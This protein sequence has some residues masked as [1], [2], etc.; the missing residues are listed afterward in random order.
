VFLSFSNSHLSINTNIFVFFVTSKYH[1]TRNN[2]FQPK[3]NPP[4]LFFSP[5][6]RATVLAKVRSDWWW[7]DA[8]LFSFWQI[9]WA[10]SQKFS[11]SKNL[12]TFVNL[13]IKSFLGDVVLIFKGSYLRQANSFFGSF[14]SLSTL[15]LPQRKEVNTKTLWTML[16]KLDQQFNFVSRFYP[17]VNDFFL[18]YNYK[19]ELGLVDRIFH[20]GQ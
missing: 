7:M 19:N 4:F 16:F 11:G 9:S 8:L 12:K 3:L 13:R 10:A 6:S 15:L 1:R 18:N 14:F 5:D 20:N 17:V 2:I